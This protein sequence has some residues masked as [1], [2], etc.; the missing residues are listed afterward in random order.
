MKFSVSPVVRCAVMP[1]NPSEIGDLIKGLRRLSK[2]DPC[3]QTIVDEGMR[4][5]RCFDVL[6]ACSFIGGMGWIGV[7]FHCMSGTQSQA[8]VILRDVGDQRHDHWH[9][10]TCTHTHTHT[11]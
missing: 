4:M 1:S 10:H 9:H 3:V 8:C 2:S 11:Q 7:P 6:V 5:R